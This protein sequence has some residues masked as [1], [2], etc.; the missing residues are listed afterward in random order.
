MAAIDQFRNALDIAAAGVVDHIA[1]ADRLWSRNA[2]KS[3]EL[4][5]ALPLEG[6]GVQAAI[7]IVLRSV[8]A[9]SLQVQKPTCAAH[10]HAPPLI[11][12]V[13]AAMLVAASNQSLDSWD[14][15]PILTRCEVAMIEALA[16]L[17]GWTEPASGVFTSGGTQSNLTALA[18]AREYATRGSPARV[19]D[20]GLRSQAS[21]PGHLLYC[22]ESAHF[23]IRKSAALLGLGWSNVRGIAVDEHGAMSATALAE[24][25]EIDK[26]AGLIPTAIVATAGTTDSGAI[27][28]I[29][30]IAAI[31]G[32]EAIWLHVDAAYG[33]GLLLSRRKHQIQAIAQADSITLDFHKLFFQA[34][35]CSAVLIRKPEHW[36]LTAKYAEYLNRERDETQ[37]ERCNLVTR[38]L[39]T[40]RAGDVLKLFLSGLSLGTATLTAMHDHLLDLAERSCTHLADRACFELGLPDAPATIVLFRLR[41]EAGE[42]DADIDLVNEGVA[43]RCIERGRVHIAHTLWQGRRFLK[44]T[45]VN[46]VAQWTDICNILDEIERCA[47]AIRRWTRRTQSETKAIDHDFA[48]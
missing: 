9:T 35:P 15:S 21:G 36:Q 24:Q 4:P 48:G 13:V 5:E 8:L 43:L 29:A 10:L 27:D 20:V 44:M 23:S 31:A 40:S 14:Q 11:E 22:G 38:S 6:V 28:P 7:E 2:A 32:R 12:S 34:L 33:A 25:I 18:L 30:E 1:R 16:Q 3:V 46:P 17:V 19:F 39:Q 42:T 47:A 41:A 37:H 45:L 26:S